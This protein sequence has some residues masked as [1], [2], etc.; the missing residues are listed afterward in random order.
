MKSW[1]TILIAT[2]AAVVLG[3]GCHP[4]TFP[5]EGTTIQP[6]S[7]GEYYNDGAS[8]PDE[9]DMPYGEDSE[10]HGSDMHY[11][12]EGHEHEDGMG[13]GEDFEMPDE[14]RADSSHDD[15]HEGAA[16]SGFGDWSLSDDEDATD[17]EYGVP[18]EE[19]FN[20]LLGRKAELDGGFFYDGWASASIPLDPE[21]VATDNHFFDASHEWDVDTV[22]W[23]EEDASVVIELDEPFRLKSLVVQA[24]DNDS[25]L[26]SYHLPEAYPGEW[27]ELA[28]VPAVG[29]WGMQTREPI[30]FPGGIIVD[31]IRVEAL[32]GDG[33]YSIG[34][35]QAYGTPINC[36]ES[37][38]PSGHD[39]YDCGERFNVSMGNETSLWGEFFTNGW[40]TAVTPAAPEFVITNGEFFAPSHEWDVGTLWWSGYEAQVVVDL[41]GTFSID[42]FIVQADDNDGYL[43]SYHVPGTPDDEWVPAYQAPSVGGWGMQTRDSGILGSA[44]VTDALRVTALYGDGLFSVG[45]LVAFGNPICD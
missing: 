28:V 34:E 21:F 40:D 32:N 22:W 2:A 26:I 38:S 12:E 39:F 31:A 16:E 37:Y 45:E 14:G 1:K 35:V 33:F 17:E 8:G 44:I 29:G 5:M 19:D 42:Q 36:N 10:M 6:P 25:Y 24:D 9:P 4:G 15:S 3:T 13:H 11:E 30:E 20:F 41:N 7:D 43:V 27:T 18:C 23:T